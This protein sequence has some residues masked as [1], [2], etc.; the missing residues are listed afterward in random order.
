ML[1]HWH[2]ERIEVKITM[3]Y[4]ICYASEA[5][6]LNEQLMTDLREILTRAMH[7]N[8]VNKIQGVLYYADRYF[9]QCLEGEKTEILKLLEAIRLD[10]RHHNLQ[11]LEQKDIEH[12]NFKDWSMKFVRK[13]SEVKAFFA[14]MASDRFN[15][16]LLDTKS[17]ASFLLILKDSEEET[18]V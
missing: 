9:F 10:P 12:M 8:Y 1:K 16:Y 18:P 14:E 7:F 3:I 2:N 5:T 11:I 4:Q 13:R 17:L 15:P 6:S